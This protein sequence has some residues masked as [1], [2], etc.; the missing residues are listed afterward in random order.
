ML[1]ASITARTQYQ[2][3]LSTYFPGDNK[4]M[5]S[6]FRNI[7]NTSK[8]KSGLSVLLAVMLCVGVLGGLVACSAAKVA[9]GDNA[10]TQTPQTP[11]NVKYPT[12][13]GEMFVSYFSGF[14]SDAE[15][16]YVGC[17]GSAAGMQKSYIFLTHDGG[18][19][20]EETNNLNDVWPRVPT[21]AVFADDKTGF[22]CFRYDFEAAGPIYFTEDGGKAWAQLEIP[23]VTEL[24][25]SGG[26][27]EARE[28]RVSGGSRLEMIYFCA[29]EGDVNTGQLYT[30]VSTDLGKTWSAFVIYQ[31]LN[32]APVPEI[33]PPQ[34]SHLRSC[35]GN[36]AQPLS[37]RHEP[38]NR[39]KIAG[40][41]LVCIRSR[42]AVKNINHAGSYCLGQL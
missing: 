2:T 8:R 38:G 6:R 18:K 34:A 22:L 5:K 30:S 9:G 40:Y 7:L 17:T 26:I 42:P 4:I 39:V 11:V 36:L 32:A 23:A 12:L 13:N 21:C 14:T 41:K 31:N 15:G 37:K 16:W 25:G 24:F 20:W 29:P 27:G 19:S 33:V 3:V 28:I 10:L 35:P 1:L